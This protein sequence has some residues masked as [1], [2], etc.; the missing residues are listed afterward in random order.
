MRLLNGKYID[1]RLVNGSYKEY[2]L[3]NGLV[4]ALKERDSLLIS[5]SLCVNQ[6]TLADRKPE[7]AHLLD[8]ALTC[9]K[10]RNYVLEEL[11]SQAYLGNLEAET[12]L[13]KTDFQST[14][15]AENLETYLKYISK[16]IFEPSFTEEVI[17]LERRRMSREVAEMRG[18]ADFRDMLAYSKALFGIDSPYL[19]IITRDPNAICDLS[20][21][22]IIEFHNSWYHPNNANLILVGALP[23]NIEK[24]IK[25]SFGYLIPEDIAKIEFPQIQPLDKQFI[26]H[27]SAFDLLDQENP[28]ESNAFLQLGFRVPP[29]NS[30][31]SYALDMLSAILGAYE[32]DS[33]LHRAMSENSGITYSIGCKYDGTD[34][35]GLFIIQGNILAKKYQIAIDEIFTQLSFLQ[36]EPLIPFEMGLLRESAKCKIARVLDDNESCVMLIQE[37]I[38]SGILPEEY[39]E[40]I[41]NITPEDIL[42]VANKYFPDQENGKYVL[43]VRDPLKNKDSK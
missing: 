30:E 27:T 20:I 29:I 18:E 38:D 28:E 32:L 40:I 33:R 5:V 15:L 10:S 39:L 24:L 6:G 42:E 17:N 37:K 35:I 34:N 41:N 1:M 12:H 36:T 31:D 13:T 23:E 19:K 11:N 22:D 14:M 4:V 9:V 43:L 25:D 21:E 8:H 16:L 7:T 3:D 2:V 26:F